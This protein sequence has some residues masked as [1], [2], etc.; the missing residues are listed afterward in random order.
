MWLWIILIAILGI[1]SVVAFQVLMEDKKRKIHKTRRNDEF[2]FYREMLGWYGSEK[3]ILLDSISAELKDFERSHKIFGSPLK[4]IPTGYFEVL[5]AGDSLSKDDRKLWDDI[6]AFNSD[7]NNVTG[8]TYFLISKNEVA[9]VEFPEHEAEHDLHLKGIAVAKEKL[10]QNLKRD[11]LTVKNLK[12]VD[13]DG[14]EI[15]KDTFNIT[16]GQTKSE[17]IIS[18]ETSSQGIQIGSGDLSASF[19]KGN[20]SGEISQSGLTANL[21]FDVNMSVKIIADIKGKKIIMYEKVFF[22]VS[23]RQILSDIKENP[24]RFIQES[25]ENDFIIAE[26]IQICSNIEIRKLP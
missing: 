1:G 22:D 17:G 8:E 23:D 13:I 14:V 20:F 7:E 24:D 19:Q 4:S 5:F 10:G 15:L 25:R 21:S 6:D 11:R 26:L 18:G 12:L 9:I 3:K 2:L 16:T